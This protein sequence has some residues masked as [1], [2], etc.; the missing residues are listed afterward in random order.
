M[1]G[2]AGYI[3]DFKPGLVS[4]MNTTQAHRGPDGQGIFEDPDAMAALGHVRLSIL[5]LTEAAAQPMHSPDGRFVI[6]FNG[7]I[8]NFAELRQE[9]VSLGYRF[10]SSGDTEVL[11]SGLIEFGEDF[12]K[13]LNGIF[14]FALWD[15][16]QRKLLLARDHLGVKP[17]YYTEPA[18]GTLLFA[19]EIKALFAYP[20]LRREP[21]FEALQQHLAYC[22]A[23]DQRTALKGIKRL[24][25]GHILRWVA[26]SGCPT[27]HRYW[28]P[29]FDGCHTS[30]KEDAVEELRTLIRQ[31]TFRQLVSDV[32]VGVLLSGG[33]DSS[34]ITT[35]A[36]ERIKGINCYTVKYPKSHN[37]LDNFTD[38]LPYAR[39]LASSLCLDLREIEL[40]P[41]LTELWPK[42]VYHL[43]EPIADPA[44]IA[45]FLMCKL[46][47]EQ[48]VPVLLSGQGG[49]ELF[50]GYPRYMVMHMTG[51]LKHMPS[52]LRRIVSTL[53]GSLPGARETRIGS[54]MRR[55][56]RGLAGFALEPE[57][58][59][60]SLCANSL[61]KDILSILSPEF[62]SALNG[63]P[64]NYDCLQHMGSEALN[65]L[66][67]LQERDL[68]IYLTNHNLL[69]T[70]KTSMAVGVE[71]RVP[72]LDIELVNSVVKYPYEWLLAKGCT[73]ALF[74][75]AAR[76]VLPG[77]IIDRP[78]AGLGAPYRK[79]LRYDLKNMWNDLTSERSVRNRGWFDHTALKDIRARSQSGRD[80]LYMLQWAVLTIELWARQFLDQNPCRI[81]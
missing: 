64:F 56:R 13:R 65:G 49:D 68:S 1:C 4:K 42:L 36:A 67:K 40:L 46:A 10:R 12:V 11:L 3:G 78:K 52:S 18:P 31:A 33:M 81:P 70:D 34:Y 59:F 74:R 77:E 71:T 15:R 17:L 23:S 9:L 30:N 60:L 25:P 41:D 66:Q 73:K 22:H 26:K 32:P 47:R 39:K 45:S 37:I 75:E 27:V 80:D 24:A 35:I 29:P 54:T 62:K 48:G 63:R 44:C 38:D 8:Y 51:W 7:E 61:Q 72:L 28:Q 69:Y 57:E 21:D 53:A 6:I 43:D 76:S 58:R 50:C 55:I 16:R 2:I 14:A 19:S 20:G 5:D 79:W